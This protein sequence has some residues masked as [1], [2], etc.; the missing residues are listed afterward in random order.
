MILTSF[1]FFVSSRKSKRVFKIALLL[2]TTV[3]TVFFSSLRCYSLA[4]LHNTMV[5]IG[6]CSMTRSVFNYRSPSIPFISQNSYQFHNHHQ[7]Q[8]FQLRLPLFCRPAKCPTMIFLP[9]LFCCLRSKCTAQL[10]FIDFI[11][12]PTGGTLYIS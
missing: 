10:I 3:K 7:S 11:S 6:P 12:R 5:V 1:M 4:L 8:P 2:Y 9:I